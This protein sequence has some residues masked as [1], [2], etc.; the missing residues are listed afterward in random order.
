MYKNLNDY[1]ILYMISEDN[2]FEILYN[3]YK[4][5]IYKT[6]LNYRYLFKNYGY[7]LDDLMQIGYIT[8]YKAYRLYTFDGAL[9]YTYFLNSLNKHLINEI[10]I[11]DTYKRK[12]LNESFSY[13]NLIPNTNISYI[14][15][16]PSKKCDDYKEEARRFIIFK[17]S[18]SYIN[19]CVFEMFYNGYNKMEIAK[20]L[21]KDQNIIMRCLREI[22]KQ[23]KVQNY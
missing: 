10:R 19:S 2:N 6:V 13:D 22:K 23:K 7:D 21:E 17:N 5:L 11:N 16:I 20:F 1:E 12:C 15:V 8:L 18:L 9:F 4:P 14:D 3:K